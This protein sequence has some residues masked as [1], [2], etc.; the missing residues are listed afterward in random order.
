M[1]PLVLQLLGTL[2][3]P[4]ASQPPARVL[5]VV[6]KIG[7]AAVILLFVAGGIVCLLIAGWLVLL[8]LVG[9]VATAAIMGGFLLLVAACLAVLRPTWPQPH[10]AAQP[11]PPPLAAL[12]Q[13]LLA[14][15]T[16]ALLASLLL[17][18]A[19]GGLDGGRT[20]RS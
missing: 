14:H 18:A 6:A 13:L 10:A 16:P 5:P 3:P 11:T 15:K 2:A 12:E 17:G 9:Q 19:A 1:L 4:A 7:L 20:S 8:P